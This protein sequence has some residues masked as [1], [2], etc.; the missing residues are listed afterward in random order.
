MAMLSVG[1]GCACSK[2]LE[3]CVVF[4]PMSTSISCE[5]GFSPDW[6]WS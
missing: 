1:Y 5:I 4:E 6:M 2:L 3:A